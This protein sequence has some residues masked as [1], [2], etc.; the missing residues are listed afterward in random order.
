MFKALTVT[1]PG[2]TLFAG[3]RTENIDLISS[4]CT[5]DLCALLQA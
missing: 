1:K 5:F 4:K 2:L 3:V